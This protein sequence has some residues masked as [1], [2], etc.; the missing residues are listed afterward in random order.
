MIALGDAPARPARL[1]ALASPAYRTFLAGIF[2]ANLGGWMQMTAQGWLVL[3]LTDSPASLGLASFAGSVPTLLLTLYAGVLADRH[4]RR[5]LLIAAQVVAVAAALL[6]GLLVALGVV[7]LWHIVL[8]AFVAGSAQALASPA[9]Q[10]IV[11]TLVD[12]AALGNA[13]ALNSAQFNLSRIFGPALAGLIVASVGE[14]ANFW[15]NALA[16]FVVI[17]VLLRIRLP[18]NEAL[19]RLEAGLWSNLLDGL[20]YAAGMRVLL[21]LLLLACAPA[22]FILPYLSLMPV[23]ARDVLDIGAPGLGL[24]TSAI[25]LGAFGGAVAFALLRPA[26]A[27]ARVVLAG[28]A[29]M[30]GAIAIFS[31]SSWLP[32][33]CL[34]LAVL[35]AAQVAY[36]TG[37]NTLIQLLS[38]PRLRGRILSLYILASLGLLPVGSL[39]AGIVAEVL[40]APPTLVI[41]GGLAA[42]WLLAVVAWAPALLRLRV[43]QAV[44]ADGD[45]P[46]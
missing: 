22:L 13:V 20:R 26:G 23:Y 9:F 10:A 34:A 8:I 21:A 33:S 18:P 29:A 38:P 17:I 1:P 24:L 14:A 28:L 5:R 31:A 7:A 40:G 46:G 37:T 27:N 15:L 36:Y 44:A 39:G 16:A 41:G 12:R 2:V 43:E 6:L 30:S 4:D 32:L 19:S 45:P 11:S 42:V 35:G 3:R 25:G